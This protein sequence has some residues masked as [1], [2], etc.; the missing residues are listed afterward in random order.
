VLRATDDGSTVLV[1]EE[2]VG[3]QLLT[4]RELEVVRCVA[5]G[6][7][8][9][10]IAKRLWIEVPTVRKHLEH[11]YDKLGVRNRT[12]AVAALRLAPPPD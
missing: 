10:E 6:L 12:A 8:N 11:V 5:E 7:T 3:A 9:E 4:R 1:R 2:G